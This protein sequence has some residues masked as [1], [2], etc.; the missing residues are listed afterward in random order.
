L[1]S[2]GATLAWEVIRPGLT[3]GT[4]FLGEA[5]CFPGHAPLLFETVIFQVGDD[6]DYEAWWTATYA[7]AM[8]KHAQAFPAVHGP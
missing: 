2:N 7:E 6:G 1:G 5:R 4:A 3:V 8:A